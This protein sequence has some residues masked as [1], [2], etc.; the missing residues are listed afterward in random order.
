MHEINFAEVIAQVKKAHGW[1]G[2]DLAK[3]LD[4]DPSTVSKWVRGQWNPN[5]EAAETLLEMYHAVTSSLD[6]PQ[7]APENLDSIV[8]KYCE[9]DEKIV[10]E[11]AESYISNIKELEPTEIERL[12]PPDLSKIDQKPIEDGYSHFLENLRFFM[13][14]SRW[15]TDEKLETYMGLEP[16]YISEFGNHANRFD[17]LKVIEGM[18]DLLGIPWSVM[19]F[20]NIAK[21]DKYARMRQ[22]ISEL[23]KERLDLMKEAG[24]LGEELGYSIGYPNP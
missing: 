5:K 4:V 8:K 2:K 14:D 1:K 7:E 15:D 10:R 16:G 3:V 6:I 20:S 11:V 22:R 12:N 17:E 23:E 18:C 19:V 24:A 13:K 21:E 9:E